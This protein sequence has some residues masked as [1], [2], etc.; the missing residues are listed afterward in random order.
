MIRNTGSIKLIIYLYYSFCWVFVLYGTEDAAVKLMER[1]LNNI[2]QYVI[3]NKSI[4][5]TLLVTVNVPHRSIL[6]QIVF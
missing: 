6:G 4:S 1:Y 5:K 2:K 3:Y